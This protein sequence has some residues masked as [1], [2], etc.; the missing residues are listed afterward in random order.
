MVF[1]MSIYMPEGRGNGGI[2]TLDG[3]LRAMERGEIIEAQVTLCDRGYNLHATFGDGL[4][5]IIPREESQ[6]VEAGEGIKDIAIL[7]RVGKR[8]AVKLLDVKFNGGIPF[9]TLSR[10]AAQAECMENYVSRLS[11]GDIIPARVTHLEG[12]GAFVDVGCGICSLL[13]I[14]AISVSRI[15]HPSER[16]SVG[17]CIY[18]VVKGRDER[19]R[20]T[21][22]TKELFGTWEENAALFSEGQTVRGRVRSI[23]SYGIFVELKPNLAGLAEWREEV[24]AGDTAAVFIKAIIP[25]KMKVKLIIIDSQPS[26]PSAEAPCYFINPESV[27]HIDRWQYSPACAKKRIE[28]VFV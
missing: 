5:G 21:V 9:F 25:E 12:F 20:I 18:L 17:E 8:V 24:Y 13:S 14:D 22:S 28:S 11:A 16:L 2:R 7:T 1:K 10:R 19:G 23:E 15:S 26:E 4:Y 6:F 27:T 3:A